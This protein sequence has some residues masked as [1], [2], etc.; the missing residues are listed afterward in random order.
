MKKT[1]FLII[2][3]II[4]SILG[5]AQG[6]ISSDKEHGK[7]HRFSVKIGVGNAFPLS[8]DAANGSTTSGYNTSNNTQTWALML[9]DLPIFLV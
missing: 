4:N 6:I 5:R 8:G 9:R 7:M 1:A 3:V 2:T